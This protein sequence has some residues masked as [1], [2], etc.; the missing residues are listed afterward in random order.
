MKLK[1]IIIIYFQKNFTHKKVIFNSHNP[2]LK[3]KN[4]S[5]VKR[6]TNIMAYHVACFLSYNNT[7]Y[8]LIIIFEATFS[9]TRV[10]LSIL[11]ITTVNGRYAIK[12]NFRRGIS[13]KHVP[14]G[15]LHRVVLA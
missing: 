11:F 13:I 7:T 10:Y 12:Y 6:T 5:D 4:I 9:Y 2:Q 3:K 15:V 14:S 1:K 8:N